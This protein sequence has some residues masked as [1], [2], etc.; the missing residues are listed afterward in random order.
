M[1]ALKGATRTLKGMIALQN[2]TVTI[3][4]RA[5]VREI[6]ID[7]V[8]GQVTVMIGPNGAGKSTLLRTLTGEHKPASGTIKFDNKP[9]TH[10]PARSLAKCRA[11]VEQHSRLSFSFPV[12]EVV[13]MGRTPHLEGGESRR[14]IDIAWA[15]MEKA[16][17]THLAEQSY[18][19]LSGG[20]RQRVDLARALT[21]IWEATADRNRYLLLDEPTASLDIAHQ[22]E[23]LKLAR[24]VAAQNVSVFVVLHDL[25]LAAQYGDHVVVLHDGCCLANGQPAEVLTSEIIE[26]AFSVPVLVTPHPCHNCPLIVPIA[27]GRASDRAS[28]SVL[29]TL[30]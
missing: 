11:V 25:N 9:L 27:S 6:S 29:P 22:H 12:L 19:T 15:A 16:G 21:Q 1:V 7:I 23:T 2:I 24:E 26:Q 20:E 30:S 5:L 13:L 28:D 8:P 3:G 4:K 10:W 17:V 14:D 18:T